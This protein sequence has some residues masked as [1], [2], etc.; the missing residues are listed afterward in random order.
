MPRVLRRVKRRREYTP[1]QIKFLTTGVSMS[2]PEWG[3]P[4]KGTARWP[5]IRAAWE[6]LRE[7]LLPAWIAEHPCS[8]PVA[9]WWFDAKEPRVRVA[10]EAKI[11]A[12]EH[13][14]TENHY[15]DGYY[16]SLN[17]RL[18]IVYTAADESDLES[19]RQYLRRIGAMT[20]AELK[21]L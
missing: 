7:Q 1:N 19:E 6:E 9:F 16:R 13:A 5:V 18:G 15:M 21:L 14:K 4:H 3:M 2:E 8:R 20:E 10:G 12:A 17:R 11:E